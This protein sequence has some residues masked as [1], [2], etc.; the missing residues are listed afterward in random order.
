MGK[1]IIQHPIYS[2]YGADS[3]GNVYSL[4]NGVNKLTYPISKNGYVSMGLF[5]GKVNGKRKYKWYL[6]HRFIAEVFIPN[7]QNKGY[8]NHKNGIKSDNRVE[9]L[10]WVT[11]V[12]NMRHAYDVL[13]CKAAFGE[14]SGKCILTEDLVKYIRQNCLPRG[15]NG[16][17]THKKM[18]E[19]LGV[20]ISAIQSVVSYKTWKHI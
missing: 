9:N 7:L 15:E 18:A 13:G 3:N 10:E 11:R 16:N 14:N 8:V 4:K 12:E 6:Q 17:I 20:S 19:M 5:L 1:S 2:D